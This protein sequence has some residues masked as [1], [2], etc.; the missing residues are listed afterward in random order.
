[1]GKMDKL[2][3]KSKLISK[4]DPKELK[5]IEDILGYHFKDRAVLVEALTHRSLTHEGGEDEPDYDRLEYL[6]DAVLQLCMSARLFRAFP[7]RDSGALTKLRRSLVEKSTLKEVAQAFGL[8]QFIRMGPSPK[9]EGRGIDGVAADVVEAL[10]GA[11]YV[12]SGEDVAIADRVVGKLFDKP[13]NKVRSSGEVIRR[14]YK[15]ELQELL[16]KY[17]RGP[18]TYKFDK[19]GPDHEPE[20]RV[21]VKLEDEVIGEGRGT[22]RR[23]AE[24]DA[25]RA[26]LADRRALIA[27]LEHG[28]DSLSSAALS[29]MAFDASP[30]WGMDEGDEDD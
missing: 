28:S 7:S 26:A 12:D 23:D 8:R 15:S 21:W 9:Y 24:Q 17:R 22:K 5:A 11:V 20:F 14:N 4:P 19:D 29:P 2:Y 6:G 3:L 18:P 1:M 27:R 30:D 25:A 13:W 10:I 16:A